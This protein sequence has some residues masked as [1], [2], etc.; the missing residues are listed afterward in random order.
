VGLRATGWSYDRIAKELQLSK[1]T[2]INW[3]KVLSLQISNFRAIEL[4]ALQEKYSLLKRQR[5]ELLGQQMKAIKEELD[6]RNLGEIP[7]EKLFNLLLRGHA[8]LERD[9]IE[10]VFQE[11]ALGLDLLGDINSVTSWKA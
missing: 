8:I 10:F 9:D 7:T 1:Q 3:S 4:E 6:K 11:E 5:I 2:L